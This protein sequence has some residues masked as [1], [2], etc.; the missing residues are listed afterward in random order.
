MFFV[1]C[2]CFSVV[3]REVLEGLSLWTSFRLM[4]VICLPK[5]VGAEIDD[6]TER[7]DLRA[8]AGGTIT[9][10]EARLTLRG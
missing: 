5:D 4:S 3:H 1:R 2:F 7:Q 9:L 8:G 10:Y 6:S